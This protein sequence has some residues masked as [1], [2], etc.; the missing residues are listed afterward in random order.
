MSPSGL[1]TPELPIPFLGDIWGLPPRGEAGGVAGPGLG[2]E[3]TF[4][5]IAD[6]TRIGEGL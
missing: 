4:N 3:R 1:R 2:Q 5:D 6:G